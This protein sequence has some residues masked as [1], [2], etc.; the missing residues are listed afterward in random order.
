MKKAIVDRLEAESV[1]ADS[2]A[3]LAVYRTVTD[4]FTAEA[5]FP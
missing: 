2:D 3:L 1:K 4:I 5:P